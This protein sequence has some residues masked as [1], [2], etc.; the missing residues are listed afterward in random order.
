MNGILNPQP[1]AISAL[2]FSGCLAAPANSTDIPI[3]HFPG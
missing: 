2:D 3:A 1:N